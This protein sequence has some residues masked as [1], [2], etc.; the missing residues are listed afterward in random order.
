MMP[1]AA[2]AAAVGARTEQGSVVVLC[3]VHRWA[4]E[5]R[6]CLEFSTLYTIRRNRRLFGACQTARR[7][8]STATATATTTRRINGVTLV[9]SSTDETTD[10]TTAGAG[11][12]K[13]K[14]GMVR[15]RRRRGGARWTNI[16]HVLG[17]RSF[18]ANV[19]E[20]A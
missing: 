6:C 8:T 5:R 19:E 7:T 14:M 3:V 11:K 10:T 1:D 16:Y 18:K 20:S 4:K 13:K 9:V 15:D 2:E 12:K 17:T